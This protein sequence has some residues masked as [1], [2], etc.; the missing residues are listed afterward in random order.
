MI[1]KKL[2]TKAV[3]IPPLLKRKTNNLIYSN[4]SIFNN[5]KNHN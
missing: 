2:Y 3:F 4:S 5:K 1:I